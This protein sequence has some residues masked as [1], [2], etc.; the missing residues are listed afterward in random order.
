MTAHFDF[1]II[2]DD[3]A[4]LCAAACAGRAGAR[5]ALLRSAK[6]NKK[7]NAGALPNIPNFIWRRLELQEYGLSL[8]P[9]SARVTL[10]ESGEPFVTLAENRETRAVLVKAG[11]RDHALWEDFVE[12]ATGLASGGF[13]TSAASGALMGGENLLAEML[14][15]M[16]AL[17]QAG[18]LAG[19][20]RALLDDCFEDDRLK[21]HIAAHSLA[22][23]GLGGAEPGSVL[24]LAEFF[25]SDAWR[26]RAEGDGKS[27]REI[28]EKACDLSGV[29]TYL[30]TISH[31]SSDSGKYKEIILSENDEKLKTRYVFFAT[32]DAAIEA[33]AGHCSLGSAMRGG[34][35]ATVS[36][37][38]KL[39]ERIEPPAQ[40][41]NAIFQI[42]DRGTDLQA[43]RDAVN[44]GRL[45]ERLPVEF[46]ILRTGSILARSAY[47]P[48][49]FYEDGE[50]RGW[51]S[52]DRQAVA[53][54]I[55]ERLISR[56]PEMANLI[57][58]TKI[59]VTGAVDADAV[60]SD[61]ARIIV[62]PARH[63]SISAAVKLIDRVMASDG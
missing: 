55:K 14:G 61:C 4:S 11:V 41:E 54:R 60:F 31:V 52:Q 24:A 8:E 34:G 62:Q 37:R 16:A 17:N 2:G 42:I 22:P 56:M 35:G 53:A 43:A 25:D 19:S 39:S 51:T 12:E 13:I 29:K 5:T 15:D 49:V 3:E 40:D 32:P 63:N 58:K 6:S 45:P 59:E 26:V 23:A 20:C 44:C 57:R 30:N 36:I 48:A 18:R 27:L 46:E 7:A 21:D 10:F 47:C 38:L 9:V 1:L 33:G 50:W 28:L